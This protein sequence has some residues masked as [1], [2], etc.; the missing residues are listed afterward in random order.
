MSAFRLG[1]FNVFYWYINSIK[2]IKISL[3]TWATCRHVLCNYLWLSPVAH[4]WIYCHVGCIL[5][6]LQKGTGTAEE[7]NSLIYPIFPGSLANVLNIFKFIFHRRHRQFFPWFRWES[8]KLYKVKA[9]AWETE[10]P[11]KLTLSRTHYLTSNKSEAGQNQNLC[12]SNGCFFIS[13]M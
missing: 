6:G 1:K 12:S 9:T 10:L 13:V 2:S 4:I 8:D 7:H 3:D 5:S 11:S